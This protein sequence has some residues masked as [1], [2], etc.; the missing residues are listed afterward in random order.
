MINFFM[1]K[2]ENGFSLIELIVCL[3]IVGILSQIGFIAFRSY[4]RKAKAFAAK[5]ALLNVM[6][7]C[8][9]NKKIGSVESFTPLEPKSYSFA[10]KTNNCNG[11]KSEGLVY[12]NPDNTNELPTYFYDHQKE[13]VHCL[14]NGFIKN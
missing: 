13:E 14:Y 9:T 3:I 2:K 10:S 5:T 11:N 7:E 6:R 1:F 8:L 12:L 4:S